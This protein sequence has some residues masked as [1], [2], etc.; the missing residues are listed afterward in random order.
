MVAQRP[1]KQMPMP[2]IAPQISKIC[3]C[4][5]SGM[6]LVANIC[7]LEDRRPQATWNWLH[8]SEALGQHSWGT[9]NPILNAPGC[10]GF[11]P[12]CPGSA[13]LDS[14]TGDFLGTHSH[15]VQSQVWDCQSADTQEALQ[16]S[17]RGIST[18]RE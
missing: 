10:T 9:S 6:I 1:S 16:P 11:S 2:I 12:S 7:L 8:F 18:N 5:V 13:C 3:V 14:L 17:L 15:S 4:N